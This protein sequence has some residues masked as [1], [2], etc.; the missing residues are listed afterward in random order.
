MSKTKISVQSD[1]FV[2][3]GV[4]THTVSIQ[5]IDSEKFACVASDFKVRQ[6]N[7]EYIFENGRVRCA[8]NNN[9]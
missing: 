5:T 8:D 7:Y 9:K 3:N 4:L 1:S 2:K 6:I